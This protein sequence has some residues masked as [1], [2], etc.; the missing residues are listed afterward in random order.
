MFLTVCRC[1]FPSWERKPEDSWASKVRQK[2]PRPVGSKEMACAV[3]LQDAIWCSTQ[4]RMRHHSSGRRQD[5]GTCWRIWRDHHVK[6]HLVVQAFEGWIWDLPF[7]GLFL[8]QHCSSKCY[9]L[10]P[11]QSPL[12]LCNLSVIRTHLISCTVKYGRERVV[13]HQT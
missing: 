4:R 2:Q 7:F 6:R 8:L 13:I 11:I 9:F 12:F 5:P 3:R 1:V 10:P